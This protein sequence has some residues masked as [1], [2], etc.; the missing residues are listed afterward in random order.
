[1][2]EKKEGRAYPMVGKRNTSMK[3]KTGILNSIDFIRKQVPILRD[4][5]KQ[6][7][8][9]IKDSIIKFVAKSRYKIR[10]SIFRFRILLIEVWRWF[11]RA[12]LYIFVIAYF[13]AVFVIG[14]YL[15]RLLQFNVEN[16]ELVQIYVGLGAMLTGVIAVIFTLSTFLIQNAATNFSA[17]F[18]ETMVKDRWTSAIYLLIATSSFMF[19]IFAFLSATNLASNNHFQTYSITVTIIVL[20]LI[21]PLLFVLL[22]RVRIRINPF[23]GLRLLRNQTIDY[24]N[25]LDKHAGAV[26]KLLISNPDVDKKNEGIFKA[27]VFN[28]N[29]TV[30][31]EV[32]NRLIYLFDFHD[33]SLDE[34][35]KKLALTTIDVITQILSKYLEIRSG[36]SLTI[37]SGVF[38]AFESDSQS[39][40]T[41]N[42]ERLVSTGTQYM[43]NN[44]DTGASHVVSAL[45]SLCFVANNIKTANQ[46]GTRENAVLSQCQGYLSQYL[47]AAIKNGNT[48][49]LYQGAKWLSSLGVLIV[50]KNNNLGLATIFNSLFKIASYGIVINTPLHKVV[51]QEALRAY[52]TILNKLAYARYFDTRV[53]TKTIFEHLT[54]LID[55][56]FN[57]VTSRGLES[58]FDTITG[59]SSIFEGI[60]EIVFNLAN[61]VKETKDERDKRSDKRLMFEIA[62]NLGDAARTMAEKIKNADHLL[63]GT[64]AKS[65]ASICEL[66]I[67]LSQE[68]DWQ[69]EKSELIKTAESLLYKP[70]LFVHE[71]SKIE[72]TLNGFDEIV[73]TYAKV[74]LLALDKDIFGIAEVAIKQI[75]SIAIQMLSKEAGSRFGYTEPRIMVRACYIGV[76]ALKKEKH[77]LIE[78][79]KPLI[80]DFEKKYVAL[81]FANMPEGNEPTSPKKDQLLHEVVEVK[82]NFDEYDVGAYGRELRRQLM[83][84]SE[85]LLVSMIEK[86]DVDRFTVEMWGVEIEINRRP[87]F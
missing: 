26:S 27:Q 81:W 25:N 8:P 12:I 3:I 31:N 29:K 84:R 61:R 44:D 36:S 16:G 85:D 57:T 11:F 73:E 68:E 52:T 60:Q 47:E 70:A 32:N 78:K 10:Y 19:F 58:S 23:S 24:L 62:D 21:F 42:L 5:S 86:K 63:V 87:L 71:A 7:I 82:E 54:A 22:N 79:L 64:I 45:G 9:R 77:D 13:I 50:D 17:G 2:V 15:P 72:D 53:H 74:G 51:Y 34:K 59:L 48:E 49:A 41:P 66:F 39:F 6:K 43:K 1:M 18:Y 40:L 28:A 55:A 56:A 37:P 46:M 75:H 80:K 67:S 38:L 14:Y 65:I 4:W 33:K 69:S 35:E 20:G 76:Y 30:L 83:D